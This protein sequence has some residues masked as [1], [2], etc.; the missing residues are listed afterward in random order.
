MIDTLVL[1]KRLDSQAEVGRRHFR[2]KDPY[3]S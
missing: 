3:M 1:R 2:K